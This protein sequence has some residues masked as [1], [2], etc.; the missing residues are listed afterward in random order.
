MFHG[1]ACWHVAVSR[2]RAAPRPPVAHLFHLGHG[3][4]QFV[5]PLGLVLPHQ[6]HAPG[7]GLAAAAGHTGIDQGVEHPP[8]AMPSRV[9]AGTPAVVKWTR[10]APHWAPQDTVRL[11]AG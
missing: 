3:R 11:N 7:Q 8:I 10:E 1:L 6:A 2:C 4:A 9:M 5:D